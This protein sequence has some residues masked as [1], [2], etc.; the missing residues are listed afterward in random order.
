MRSKWTAPVFLAV[1]IGWFGCGRSDGGPREEPA[2]ERTW[3]RDPLER[4]RG[5]RGAYPLDDHA[6]RVPEE[7]ELDCPDVDLVRYRGDRIS[8]GEGGVRVAPPFREKLR[9][10][11]RIA[12][13]VGERV[14]KRPP[15]AI[16]HFGAYNCRRVR[17]R[18]YRLS[19]H[20]F[21]NGIDVAGFRFGPAPREAREDLPRSLWWRTTVSVADDWVR[22]SEDDRKDE[23]RTLRARFLRELVDRLVEE[24]VFRAMLGPAHGRHDN[25]FHF[26]HGPFRYRIV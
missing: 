25:H 19:E 23:A 26:D 3:T 10:L 14:M 7:G 6:R 17:G 13:E 11:E 16:E 22:G 15:E 20:A 24:D 12:A 2:A 8:F 18:P 1:A 21:G 4:T 9:A 5:D